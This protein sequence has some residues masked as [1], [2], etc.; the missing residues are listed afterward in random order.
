MNK[1]KSLSERT[2]NGFLWMLSG[3]GIQ[4]ISQ[5]LVLT[6]LARLIEPNEFGVVTAAMVVI[7]FSMIFSS[8][9]VGPAIVQR[10]DLNDKHINTGFVI[11]II[12]GAFFTLS[13]YLL[14]GVISSFFRIEELQS[15]LKVLS[16]VFLIQGLYMTALSLLER[17]LQYKTISLINALAYIVG[18]GLTG[19]V[20]GL[21]GYGVYA[22]VIA[23]IAQETIKLILIM[24]VK[25]H[26]KKLVISLEA[27]KEL[28]YFGGGFTIARI[29][30]YFAIQGDNFVVGRTLGSELLGFYGRIY[31]L[32]ALPA[33]LFGQVVDKVL[34]SAMSKIQ[35]EKNRLRQVYKRGVVLVSLIAVPASVFA[36]LFSEEIILVLLGNQWSD[37]VLPFKILTIG[38]FFRAS[39]KISESVARSTGAVYR[40]A[41]RQVIYAV[42]VIGGSLIGQHWG[43]IGV[44][45]AV[46]IAL[47]INFLLMANLS[48]SILSIKTIEYIK[49][50]IPSI[51]NGIV[52]FLVLGALNISF[53]NPIMT[54][55]VNLLLLVISLLCTCM[56]FPRYFLG[57]EGEWIMRFVKNFF[58]KS[59]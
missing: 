58:L 2:F 36:F 29:F 55:T 53:T 43:L 42:A 47:I 13:I 25:K 26:T 14:S 12:M 15:V 10:P 51:L 45:I 7:G 5:L 38:M 28:M 35:T 34:F 20:F 49:I 24:K 44:T 59:K 54:L 30:N 18:Y 40:R 3:K 41:W 23:Q 21:N 46:N 33:S 22:L 8:L 16:L 31:Q 19:I 11:S 52:L 57:K 4:G 1:K 6:I 32:M 39:Y 17:D 48:S 37:A 27:L 50:H 9:G 56:L